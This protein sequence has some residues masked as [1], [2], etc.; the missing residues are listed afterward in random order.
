MALA[1][2]AVWVGAVGTTRY[3]DDNTCPAPGSGTLAN[4]YCRIQDGICN[5]VAGDTVSVAPGNYNE[6]L[7]MKPGVSLVSQGGPSVTTIN[8][9]GIPCMLSNNF[10]TRGTSPAQCS[11]VIFPTGH[12]ASTVLSGF[13]IT[14][15]QGAVLTNEVAGG[16][17]FVFSSPTISNNIVTNNILA[18][19]RRIFYGA[20]I[21]VEVGSP[22]ITGN[23]ISGNRAIPAAGTYSLPSF[24]YGAGMYVSF[25]TSPT[26]TNNIISGNIAGDPNVAFSVGNGG[27]VS[28]WPGDANHPDP[29]L[30]DRNTIA[31]NQADTTGGGVTVN[32]LVN[33]QT[34]AIVSNNV[35][36]G[37]KAAY[38]GGVYLYFSNS[39]TVNNTIVDNE[40]K[41]GGGVYS[42]QSDV[43]LPIV[44]ANNAIVGNRLGLGGNGGGIYTLDLTPSFDPTIEANDFFNNQKN[45][46]AGER[47]D[48]DTIGVGGNFLADPNFVNLAGRDFHLSLGSPAIDNAF[49][50]WAPPVDRDNHVRGIDGTGTPNSPRPGDND[51]GAY[52]WQPSCVPGTET[53]NGLDDD[54]DTIVDDGFPNSDGDGL[55]DCVD[56]DD[57]NDTAMDG[58]DCLPLD[59][60]AFAA[61]GEVVDVT[62]THSPTVVSY[63]M[64]NVGVGTQYQIVSGILSRLVATGGYMEDFCV[65]AAYV[66]GNWQDPRPNPP[67][68]DGFYYMIRAVNACGVGTYGGPLID[69]PRPANACPNGIVDNDYDGSPSDLDCNDTDPNIAP[70]ILEVCDGV[71]NNCAGGADEGNPGGGFTCGSNVGECRFGVTQC[72]GGS[73]SCVG[74]VLPG[75]ELCDSR[76]NDCDGT[77]DNNVIDSD[78]DTFDDCVD[79]DDDNDGALDTADCAPLNAGSFGMPVEVQSLDVLATTPTQVTW[80]NQAIGSAT[81]Y[82][83]ATGVIATVGQ[84]SFPAGTCLT[85]VSGTPAID[86]RPVPS[87]GQAFYYMV[88]SRNACGPGTHGSAARDTHPAC[89]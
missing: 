67:P 48:G 51:V 77:V 24:G 59:G 5:G 79:T 12:T 78:G 27:G 40:A 38:G 4:P 20:G 16:G 81:Q 76:D 70:Y 43:S 14:G 55:A 33:T 42:G 66:G 52:E 82:E 30:L 60:S 61:P 85:T 75:P 25:N 19:P 46:I 13:T 37:N 11:V 64:Q 68:G 56:P 18:G 65:D 80:T 45:Q 26:I 49:A 23:T 47:T 88:K 15:G 28:I 69:L 72:A 62:V 36:V 31:D 58:A 21:H 44:I 2:L 32:S 17:I 74:G 57:D 63:T 71:D 41:F 54:C 35:I 50:A 22:I 84:V 6:S 8:G 89:P 10:C 53:C 7:R 1:P 34:Q 86:P 83:I 87:P 73:I 39:K 29:I 9:A 3:V